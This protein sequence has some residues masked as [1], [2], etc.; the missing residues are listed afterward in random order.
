MAKT[1][2]LNFA[3]RSTENCH[4]NLQAQRNLNSRLRGLSDLRYGTLRLVES[5]LH[6]S[7]E[8]SPAGSGKPPVRPA[9]VG[10]RLNTAAAA[11]RIGITP[12]RLRQLDDELQPDRTAL[13]WRL[14]D[15]RL[16]D[17]FAARRDAFRAE[18]LRKELMNIDARRRQRNGAGGLFDICIGETD[19]TV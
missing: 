16:V 10:D 12:T 2:A 15:P 19:E 18:K 14:Y 5:K 9:P 13:G 17:Q 4:P 7:E 1:P 8:R 11:A 6:R 3:D